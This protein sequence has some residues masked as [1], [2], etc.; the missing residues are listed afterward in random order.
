MRHKAMCP[1]A[2]KDWAR[3][4]A[5]TILDTTWGDTFGGSAF[6]DI[7]QAWRCD[8]LRPRMLHYVAIAPSQSGL[9]QA[10]VANPSGGASIPQPM[11]DAV[12]QA[13]VDLSP[14]FNRL[15]FDQGQ[16]SL[17]LCLG[18]LKAML[19][20]QAFAADTVL[21]GGEQWDVWRVKQLA[22]CCRRGTRFHTAPLTPE[23]ATLFVD[24]GFQCDA[25]PVQAKNAD[26]VT[27]IFAP[28]WH[29]TTRR[30]NRP[31]K[32]PALTRCAIVGAGLSGATVAHAL[33]LRGWQVT[34]FDPHAAPAGGAS[35]LPAGL[36]VPY[37]SAD[38]DPRSRISRSGVRLMLQ[39]ARQLL[40]QG[41]D[42]EPTGVQEHKR[43]TA[44]I[45]W[46]AQAGW[47]KPA[48]VVRALLAHPD[49]RFCGQAQVCALHWQDNAWVLHDAVGGELGRAEQVVFTNA[50]DCVP[51][52]RSLPTQIP[53]G[54]TLAPHAQANI[55]NL[56]AVHGTV[57]RGP[58]GPH[59][60]E[61]VLS[62]FPAFPVN[63]Q[64]SFL[65]CIPTSQ[66][67]QWLL[68]ATYENSTDTAHAAN[69]AK[70]Q[71]LLPATAAALA[72]A[73]KAGAVSAWSGTRCVSHDRLPLV[74]PLLAGPTPSLWV[75]TA[76]GSR[77]LSFSAVCAQL[78]VAQLCA[79]P[80]PLELSLTRS[81]DVQRVRRRGHRSHLIQ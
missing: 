14:G 54:Q 20:E 32:P 43:D 56:H 55:A 60:N 26:A 37:V 74:G 48:A 68:G 45:H 19:A 13:C 18:E 23:V 10:L 9:T 21:L 66:G 64:G 73:F 30:Q 69:L 28:S 78:L 76:M 63:G 25:P 17:T 47:I 38:I 5:W 46:H 79:E 77:G 53:Q 71:Q 1:L 24:V 67:L 4:N 62:T 58:Y 34:V 80:L 41:Q 33:A 57:T 11:M 59:T 72:P 3:Q 50:L 36:V 6:F 35:G 65:P 61:E 51:L 15:L 40:V 75:N 16:V 39:W 31:A 42:W 12:R 81:L 7:W 8:P 29:I 44:N 22:K 52:L 70:L 27:G 49:I 2:P